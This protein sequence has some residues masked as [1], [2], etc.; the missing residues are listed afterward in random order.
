MSWTDERIEA[1]ED[2]W[3]KGAPPARSRTS[4]AASAQRGGRQAHRLGLEQRPSP[5]KPSEERPRSPR[6]PPAAAAQAGAEGRSSE[7][8]HRCAR[9]SRACRS[10]GRDPES[11]SSGDAI[12]FH[13]P[14]HSPG[15]RRPAAADPARAAAPASY[16]PSRAPRLRTRPAC[17]IST[18]AF[19]SGRSV[20]RASPTSTSV[21]NGPN[22]GFPYC[23]THCGVAYQAQLPRRDRRPPRRFVWR[24]SRPRQSRPH[25]CG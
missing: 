1:P 17:S 7:T 24:T 3:A 2:M 22:P 19:A 25:S 4:L 16:P 9:Y 12:S 15:P 18:T 8:C 11:L 21:A 20:T 6:P 23:V 10:A 13:R 14:R 5:V